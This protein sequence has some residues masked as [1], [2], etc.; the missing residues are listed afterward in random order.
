MDEMWEEM[1][2]ER[3]NPCPAEVWLWMYGGLVPCAK[4][5]KLYEAKDEGFYC[6]NCKR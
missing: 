6:G 2:K 1:W 3:Y 4:C 5:G